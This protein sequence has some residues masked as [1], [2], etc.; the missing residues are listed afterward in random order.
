MN[1]NNQ[2]IDDQIVADFESAWIAGS[3]LTI[4]DCLAKVET[5]RRLATLAEL[6]MVD[7]EF[8]WKAN[9]R[10]DP[11]PKLLEA[12]LDEFPELSEAAILQK[13]LEEEFQVRSIHGDQPRY[14]DFEKRF[15][16]VVD[17]LEFTDPGTGEHSIALPEKIEVGSVIDDFTITS[18][19]GD[20]GMGSVFVASQDQP[21]KR[22]VA[23]KVIRM[24]LNSK[25]VIARFEAERQAL[26]M[27]EHPNIARI[28]DGGTTE[29]GQPYFAMELVHGVPITEFCDTNKLGLNDRLQIFVDVCSAVQH[30]HQKGIIHRD[31]KPGNILVG[32]YDDQYVPKVIDFGLAKAL[33]SEKMLT[34][35]TIA[36][37][38]GQILGTFKYMSP[39]QADAGTTDIDTRADIYALGI[40]LYELLTG[41]TPLDQNT[42]REHTVLKLLELIRDHDPP[43]PST[44]FNSSHDSVSFISEQRQIEPSR[45]SQ[46]LRGDLDWVVMK[47]LDKERHRRYE[48]ASGFADDVQRFLD[49]E[50]VIARPPSTSYKFQKWVRKNRGL[51]ASFA[52]IS[53]L[54]ITAIIG[55][56]V[57]AERAKQSA[58]SEQAQRNIA[59]EKTTEALEQKQ[60]ADQALK[61]AEDSAKRS[62]EVLKIVSKS[63]KSANPNEG[64]RAGMLAK[65]VLLNAEQAMDLSELD[66]LGKAEL[67]ETLTISFRGLGEFGSAI[68]TAE[69]QLEIYRGKYGNENVLTANALNSLGNG[70]FSNGK[71]KKALPVL[72]EALSIRRKILGN[73]HSETIGA[74]GNLAN[75]YEGL[76]D[77]K[78]SIELREE[79]VQL[80]EQHIGLESQIALN[81]LNN[82]AASYNQV[83]QIKKAPELLANSIKV[84]KKIYGK[85]HRRTLIAMQNLAASHAR[86]GDLD[87]ATELLVST[88]DSMNKKLGEDHPDTL[89]ANSLLTNVYYIAGQYDKALELAKQ[90]YQR[91]KKRLGEKHPDT[92]FAMRSLANSYNKAGQK[93]K[94]LGL[95]EQAVKISKE[96]LG[97]EHPETFAAQMGLAN[98]YG[99]AGALE[100][101][102]ELREKL[103]A[104]MTK[105]LGAEHPDT[106]KLMSGLG[107]SYLESGKM[108]EGIQIFEKAYQI[109][110]TRL[111][112]NHPA[113]RR[114]LENVQI[115]K[116]QLADQESEKND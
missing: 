21:V 62:N 32:E 107:A 61:E 1:G 55:T 64:G 47:A 78:K 103:Y 97:A 6:V 84:A 52:A 83:G 86:A 75:I 59:V 87:K 65:E 68:S 54:L 114:A 26:A 50:P 105:V 8:A 82:L 37:Q 2:N 3:P 23:L 43:R 20:G 38:F 28:L 57:F 100:K 89:A 79:A 72:T 76:G 70:Y 108:K 46:I 31:L 115:S 10:N 34:D 92:T 104:A 112:E 111:G 60:I 15:P 95:R 44:K 27:M 63:F 16:G 80:A 19:I 109:N 74:I 13:L 85:D 49:N 14:E 73:E 36:T 24:G 35:Q 40:I 58:M 67:L 5:D 17:S 51:V 106:V 29:D 90:T 88:L 7:I 81:A 53:T 42:L 39:E 96:V 110:K 48:T 94:A 77:I 113:T 91:T 99:E 98:Q 11:N 56:T 33:D 101:A 116:Q 102:L 4:S 30:A 18:E 93:D 9:K 66:R 41:S 45:L 25:E 71:F 22:T 69:K 12:Y